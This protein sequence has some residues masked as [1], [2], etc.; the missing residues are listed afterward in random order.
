MN[1]LVLGGHGFIGS[2]IVEES[3][4]AGHTLRVFARNPPLFEYDAEWFVG[5]FLDTVKLSEALVGIDTVIHCISTTVPATSNSDPVYDINTNLIGTVELL[6]LMQLQDVQ[7][8]IYFSSGGTVYGNPSIIPV[9]EDAPLNPICPY[10]AVKVAIEKFINVVARCNTFSSVILRPSNIFGERQGHK[11]VQGLISTVLD[12][13]VH[14]RPTVI[15]GDGSCVRDY[16]YI[17]DV[18]KLVC[19]ILESKSDGV[20]NVGSGVG[21]TINQIL[22]TIEKTTG[23]TVQRQYKANRG[24]DVNEIVLDS[25]QAQ[26]NFSWRPE[27]SLVSG[28]VTQLEWLKTLNA[29]TD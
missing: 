10:G 14:R 8:L 13:T 18:A 24:F 25:S 11:G 15:Y 7:R 26:K 1:V 21:L 19:N 28:I 4:N 29:C 3:I 6:R 2:H 12:N 20:Y 23:L 9:T 27:V 22:D 5:D 17:K 16:I